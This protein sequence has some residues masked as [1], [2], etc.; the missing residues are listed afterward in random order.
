MSTSSL[1]SSFINKLLIFENTLNRRVV[2]IRKI[3]NFIKMFY[4]SSENLN[5]LHANIN[6]DITN[7]LSNIINTIS[8]IFVFELDCS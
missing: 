8:I 2:I 5:F 4:G 3:F 6:N 1:F 7:I